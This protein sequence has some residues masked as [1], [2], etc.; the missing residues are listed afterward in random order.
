MENIKHFKPCDFVIFGVLGD[1]ARRKLI[2]SL[3]QLEKAGLL[4]PST[5]IV[6]VAR[7]EL[8]QEGFLAKVRESLDIFVKETP[9]SAAVDA[10]LARFR[11][12]NV[13]MTDG[14]QYSRLRESVDQNERVMVN[15]LAVSPSLYGNI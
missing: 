10:L 13:D 14:A 11:Y 4:E 7:H 8:T 15:Y 3:Y 9:D 12:V 6:G 5:R 2:P 1:L